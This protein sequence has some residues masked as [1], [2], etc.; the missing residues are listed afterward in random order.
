MARG[1]L[2]GFARRRASY[3]KDEPDYSHGSGR[4]TRDA[5]GNGE[6]AGLIP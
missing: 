3:S 6:F 5:R 4:Y 2:R 1:N